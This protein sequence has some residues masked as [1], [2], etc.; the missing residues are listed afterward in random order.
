[1]DSPALLFLFSIAAAATGRARPRE[2]RNVLPLEGGRETDLEERR[3][4]NSK[5]K[6]AA[7]NLQTKSNLSH[8]KLKSTSGEG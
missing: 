5:E 6:S 8:I 1:M 4:N 7:Q 3:N 2:N